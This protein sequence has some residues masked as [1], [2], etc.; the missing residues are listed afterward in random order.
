MCPIPLFE[1]NKICLSNLT[2]YIAFSNLFISGWQHFVKKSSKIWAH[3]SEY[4]IKEFQRP[5]HILFNEALKQNTAYELYKLAEF[6]EFPATYRTLW[7]TL[8]NKDGRFHRLKPDWLK[9][10]R[11][12]STDVEEYVDRSIAY[13]KNLLKETTENVPDYRY[14]YNAT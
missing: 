3:H 5:R 8:D 12:Y 2:Q 13:V 14:M 7:C 6:L 10:T 11:L 4:W 9:Q 1:C